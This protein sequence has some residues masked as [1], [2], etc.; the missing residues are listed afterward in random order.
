MVAPPPLL[1]PR[2]VGGDGT[3]VGAGVGAGVPHTVS[4]HAVH[5]QSCRGPGTAAATH[6]LYVQPRS[7]TQDS[8][9]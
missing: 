2:R 9:V 4:L 5:W 7:A 3:G 6:L 1:P 8:L